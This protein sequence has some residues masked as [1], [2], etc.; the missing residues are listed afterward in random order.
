MRAARFPLL[1]FS[2]LLLLGCPPE[3]DPGD[4]DDLVD[5][6]DSGDDDS[7]D[8]DDSGGD[9]D[10]GDD[11]DTTAPPEGPARYPTDQRHSPITP[12][13][14]DGLLGLAAID[15]ELAFDVFM[16]VGDSM[17]VDSNAL[18][19]FAGSSVD[20]GEHGHLAGTR[21]H[22]LSPNAAGV[23]SFDR[24]SEAAMIGRSAGWAIT[25]GPSP[26]QQ[27]L[28]ALS[29]RLAIIQYGTNDMQL[30]TTYLSAIWSF[31]DDLLTLVEELSSVGVMPLLLTIP[32]RQDIADGDRWLPTYNGVIR[33]IAQ[34][35]QVP[36]ADLN[37]ALQDVSGFGLASDGVHLN[38][39]VDGSYRA[40]DLTEAGLDYGNNARNLLVLEAL[41]RAVA[42]LDGSA[43]P[44]PPQPP[45][46]GAGSRLDPVLIP[47]L[48]FSDL[49]S[50]ADSDFSD[51]SAY[52]GCGA[53]QDESG[54]EVVYRLDLEEQTRLRVLVFDRGDVDVDV[55]LLDDT[56]SE[57]GCVERAH[58]VF[59]YTAEPGT[60]HLSVDS[61]VSSAGEVLSGEYL[62]LIQGLPD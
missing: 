8:D 45:L 46:A 61:F 39:L 56:A 23:S 30:G 14:R 32:P 57:A 62:L 54:P 7:A 52:T 41:D 25:G 31:G 21:D 19:C 53:D 3:P 26:L 28:A 12:A 38:T 13:V 27:E 60:W 16:K 18:S 17:T 24:V 43:P 2:L 29:P 40:C 33:T 5:D 44:D 36:L 47:S 10:S 49:R 35:L 42:A 6:D 9:D 58:R 22:F 34:G 37:L 15:D 59:E 20:L 51:L 48:P 55:H 11:D 50:T 1:T 4:D